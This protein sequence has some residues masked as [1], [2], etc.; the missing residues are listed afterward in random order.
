MV[1]HELF[2]Q[3][4]V[5]LSDLLANFV[6]CQ[7]CPILINKLAKLIWWAVYYANSASSFARIT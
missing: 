7:Y 4:M 1:S 5:H 3:L 6:N 2:E